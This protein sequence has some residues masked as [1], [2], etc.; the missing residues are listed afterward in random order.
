MNIT[1]AIPRCLKI[2][3]ASACFA[4]LTP[5]V[6]ADG[7]QPETSVVL[8]K[9]DEREKAIKVLNTDK[10]LSLLNVTLQ[11]IPEDPEPLL[12]VTPQL[13]RVE[14]GKTQLVRFIVRNEYLE[15]EKAITTQR[16]KRV[17]FE[18]IP[19]QAD[20]KTTGIGRVGVSIRQNLPVIIHPKG[21][22]DSRT[23]WEGLTWSVEGDKIHVRNDT[24]YVVRL[25]EEIRLLPSNTTAALPRAYILA[26]AHL[27]LPLPEQAKGSDKVRIF[28]ATVYG[29]AVDAYEAPLQAAPAT[30]TTV[31]QQDEAG[32]GQP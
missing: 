6:W 2:G 10:Q 26:G 17:L 23:P 28:P 13:S 32:K 29:F 1:N 19:T 4:L 27:T 12:L 3:L 15:G 8:V 14:P 22:A 16:L 18:G 31:P 24:P 20:E 30:S 7:M 21:L 5:S 9:V 11:N 25:A